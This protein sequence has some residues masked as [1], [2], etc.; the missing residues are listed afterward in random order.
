MKNKALVITTSS[1]Y[2]IV[3]TYEQGNY[4]HRTKPQNK[5]VESGMDVIFLVKKDS[6]TY[7]GANRTIAIK[8]K[9]K[10]CVDY[11]GQIKSEDYIGTHQSIK[12]TNFREWRGYF[13][14]TNDE[15]FFESELERFLPGIGECR[16]QGGIGYYPSEK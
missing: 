6:T 11:V 12:D 7:K 9:L 16:V 14:I 13:E 3:R 4:V 5:N 15:I 2:D 10:S 8:A 1:V